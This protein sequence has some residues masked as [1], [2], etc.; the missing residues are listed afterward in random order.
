M[1]RAPE[2]S[3]DSEGTRTASREENRRR[4]AH[5]R[6]T[7]QEKTDGTRGRKRGP[8]GSEG[9][10]QDTSPDQRQEAQENKKN[11]TRSMETR[12]G[13]GRSADKQQRRGESNDGHANDGRHGGRG[14]GRPL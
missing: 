12:E 7:T 13:A 1:R 4:A 10:R 5:A 6:A 11:K 3:D 2:G 9:R 8:P 14:E